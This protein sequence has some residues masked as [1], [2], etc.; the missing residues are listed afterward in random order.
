[1]LIVAL[2]TFGIDRLTKY[3][4]QQNLD[5]NV[6]HKL[7]DGIVYLTHTQNSG[8]AFSLGQRFGSFYLFFALA[9]AIFIVIFHRRVPADDIWTRVALGM[10]LGGA[11]GNALDRILTSSV[12]DFVDL[13]WW[14][15]FNV[16]DSCIVLAALSLVIRFGRGGANR[17]GT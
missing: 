8:A 7:I 10:I 15:V 4:V 17:S 14:P 9:A 3:L 6:P 12:T 1:L 2:A 16:A 5:L 11:L 13:R